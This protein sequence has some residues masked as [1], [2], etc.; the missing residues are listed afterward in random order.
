APEHSVDD[1][2]SDD[3]YEEPSYLAEFEFLLEFD[4]KFTASGKIFPVNQTVILEGQ[5]ITI[6]DKG[7]NRRR[8]KIPLVN[9][10]IIT[11]N[12]Q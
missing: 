7:I 1:L 6:T 10:K 5:A 4:P 8:V 9:L 11:T 12:P 2:Y 3:I